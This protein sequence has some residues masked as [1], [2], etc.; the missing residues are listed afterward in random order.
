MAEK[1]F[2]YRV[3]CETEVNFQY[4]WRGESE[5]PPTLCPTDSAHTI[6][7]NPVIVEERNTEV[8]TL[9]GPITSDGR[10]IVQPMSIR[11][12]Q[13]PYYT[14]DGDDV[15]NGARSG[16][17]ALR[18]KNTVSETITWQYIDDI[19]I[20]GGL[21]RVIGGEEGDIVDMELVAPA[22]S[23][24][25]NAGLGNCNLSD[26]GGALPGAILIVPLAVSNGSHDVDASAALNAS[27]VNKNDGSAPNKVTAACPVPALLKD[28][29]GNDV[30]NGHW[31]YDAT[32]GVL[33]PKPNR[34][35]SWA[36]F[37]AVIVLTKWVSAW[38]LWDLDAGTQAREMVHRF[39]MPH[40]ARK[41]LPHWQFKA[42]Y[43]KGAGKT[44]NVSAAWGLYLGRAVTG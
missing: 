28:A 35:G 31:D 2:R 42:I 4:V 17:Q 13:H 36:L 41:I 21:I 25:P 39:E 29:E 6:A 38:Q 16:G 27:L 32:T 9:D 20:L 5:G 14:G 7:A 30:P 18:Y 40:K 10:N 44:G 23:V 24:T 37:S 3:R 15:A 26:D 33:T 1:L 34:D 43:T 11:G 12:D 22:T 19:Y 8:V